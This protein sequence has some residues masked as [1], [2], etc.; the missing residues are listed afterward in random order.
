MPLEIEVR[1]QSEHRFPAPSSILCHNW[2]DTLYL[3]TD[4]VCALRKV[5][6]LTWLWKQHIASKHAR[7][8]EA[9]PPRIKRK[10]ERE[11]KKG[12]PSSNDFAFIY[13]GVS[14]VGSYKGNAWY[15]PSCL[16]QTYCH[17]STNEKLSVSWQ[18]FETYGVISYGG[19]WLSSLFRKL[20]F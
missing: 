14:N 8:H 5:W 12:V 2:R 6:V 3:S 9:R 16:L 18:F 20:G 7:K 4:A 11:K 19:V 10:K 13:A 15:N 17:L 1:G